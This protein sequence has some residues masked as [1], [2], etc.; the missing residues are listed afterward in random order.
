MLD[1][2]NELKLVYTLWQLYHIDKE[3]KKHEKERTSSVLELGG[4]QTDQN[5]LEKD[6]EARKK[7]Q[8]KENK[9]FLVTEKKLKQ[10]HDELESKRPNGIKIRETVQHLQKR[11]ADSRAALDKNSA[12]Y[13]I[14][15]GPCEF[16]TGLTQL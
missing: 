4:V 11:L 12:E 16:L 14:C 13:V 5:T 9:N 1:Q 8:G 2:L 15:L 10:Q 6:L 7:E 3:L